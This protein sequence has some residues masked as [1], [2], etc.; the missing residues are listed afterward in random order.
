VQNA[1]CER[2]AREMPE[3]TQGSA[4]RQPGWYHGRFQGASALHHLGD[5][6]SH[7]FSSAIASASSPPGSSSGSGGGGSSGGGGGGGGG[8][9]W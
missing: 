5:R 4:T 2:F 1:W 7:S 9:G 3:E 6:F 8:G